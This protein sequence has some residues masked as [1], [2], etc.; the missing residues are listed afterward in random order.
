VL[1]VVREHKVIQCMRM[2]LSVVFLL[3]YFPAGRVAGFFIQAQSAQRHFCGGVPWLSDP[4][5]TNDSNKVGY[6]SADVD[7]LVAGT[8]TLDPD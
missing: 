7:K 5:H 1:S 8:H 6:T 4:Y 2:R 3:F